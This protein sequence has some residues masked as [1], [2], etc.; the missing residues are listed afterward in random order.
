MTFS[1]VACDPARGECGVAVASK[2]LA[3]GALVPWV[4]AGVGAVATQAAMNPTYGPDGLDLLEH[5]LD[6]AAA[7]ARLTA[8]DPGAAERQAA[9]VDCRGRAAIHTGER[10]LAWAGGRSGDGWAAQGNTLVSGETIT[11]VA[12]TFEGSRDGGAPMARRL[13]EALAAGQEAGG[14]RR[15]QQGAALLVARAG[16]GYGGFDVAVDLRV[17][18]HAEPVAELQR[19]LDLHERSFGTTPD[20]DWLVVDAA[21]AAELRERLAARGHVGGDLADDLMQWALVENLEERVAGAERIDPV[22]LAAI[23]EDF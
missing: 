12:A 1:L 14:D 16:G 7:L 4:R 23:R 19:L 2:F 10:C 15:G 8:E 5:G 20:A 18:D 6:P 22:V 9:I 21:L 13:L 11:A 17:D 3:I